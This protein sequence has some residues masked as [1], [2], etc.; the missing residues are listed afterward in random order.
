MHAQRKP[1]VSTV[2][3]ADPAGS[4]LQWQLQRAEHSARQEAA[5]NAEQYRREVT[6]NVIRYLPLPPAPTVPCPG[7]DGEPPAMSERWFN[8]GLVL[9][10]IG[11]VMVG[12]FQKAGLL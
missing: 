12:F 11:A 8:F 1:F 9:L 10:G 2:Q 5:A 6:G 3:D 7:E 4:M